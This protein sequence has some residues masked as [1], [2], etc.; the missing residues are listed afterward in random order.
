[1]SFALKSGAILVL[2]FV[3]IPV[4]LA[5]RAPER[6]DSATHV[7]VG[8][9]EALYFQEAARGANQGYVVEIVIAKV[10]RGSGLKAGDT[11]YA[12]CYRPNPKAPDL[13]KLSEQEQK[14][15]LLTVDGGHKAPP[16][17]GDR[18]RVFVKHDRGKYHG[19]FPDWVD[20][21]KNE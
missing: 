13:S 20:V 4:S 11:F 8:K 3:L 12:S 21:L 10:E 6:R 18:V 2:G 1:M 7:V 17:P 14:A 5:D 19:I 15:Y 9:V 16:R